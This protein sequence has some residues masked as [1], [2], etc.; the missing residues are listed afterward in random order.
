MIFMR[1]RSEGFSL[2][3]LLTVT[4]V[5]AVLAAIIIPV[6]ARPGLENPGQL[7]HRRRREKDRPSCSSDKVS[8]WEPVPCLIFWQDF[9]E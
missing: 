1:Y 2:I 9:R 3:E 8:R 4:A 7:P 5:I 6:F